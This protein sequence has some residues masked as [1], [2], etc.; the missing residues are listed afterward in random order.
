MGKMIMGLFGAGEPAMAVPPHGT[1]AGA[2]TVVPSA[3]S[4]ARA[5]NL[6]D[7]DSK[8]RRSREQQWQLNMAMVMGA[9]WVGWNGSAV[10]ELNAPTWRIQAVDNKLFVRIR[11]K[12]TRMTADLTPQALPETSDAA[13]IRRAKYKER[14]LAHL[15]REIQEPLIRFRAAQWA[16]VCGEVYTEAFWDASA[17]EAFADDGGAFSLGECGIRIFDP[18]SVWPGAGCSAGNNGGRLWTVETIPVELARLKYNTGKIEPDAAESSDMRLRSNFEN[19]FAGNGGNARYDGDRKNLEDSV[20]VKVLREYRTAA[21]PMGRTSIVINGEVRDEKPLTWDGITHIVNFPSFNS[22]YGDAVELRLSIQRQ[23]SY[24]RLLSNWEEY[25]RTMAKGKILA[26]SG[27]NIKSNQ[28]DSEHFEVVKY[29]G[30]GPPPT[31]WMPPPM[32]SDTAQLL[33]L[34]IQAIDDIFSDHMASQGKSPAS[35]SGAAINYLTEED[36]RQHT[37]TRDLWNAGWAKTYEKCLDVVAGRSGEGGYKEDR[38]ISVLGEDRRADVQNLAPEMLAGRN[39]IVITVGAAL[40]QNKTLRSEV[41]RRMFVDGMLGDP[42]L[43]ET[44]RKTLKMTDAGLTDDVYDD[45]YLD[46]IRAES[47]NSALMQ[48]PS[49]ALA[50]RPEDGDDVHTRTHLRFMKSGDFLELPEEIQML[51]Y[52]HIEGHQASGVPTLPVAPPRAPGSVAPPLG[53]PA[54]AGPNPASS[55]AA[56]N[57]EDL[58]KSATQAAEPAPALGL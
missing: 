14:L 33:Q 29:D 19:F 18:F 51:F 1:P 57:P 32:P 25:V 8:A 13:D 27:S 3:Q 38:V 42:T 40:P 4:K 46:E 37:P 52:A 41:V 56:G 5:A 50:P 34:N 7:K 20:M 11:S 9:Q 48:G 44:R 16:A 54:G 49:G 58:L 28:F 10:Q 15:R 6:W 21:M 53:A 12:I 17:G 47:E 26:H 45:E 35:A 39:R 2:P 22:Y 23:K 43:K 31:P 55:P 30:V 24:N 36:A